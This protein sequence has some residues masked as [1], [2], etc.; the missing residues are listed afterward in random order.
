MVEIIEGHTTGPEYVKR[1]AKQMLKN[2]I[3]IGTFHEKRFVASLNTYQ[4]VVSIC[5][6]ETEFI[7]NLVAVKK[8]IEREFVNFPWIGITGPDG[9]GTPAGY[10]LWVKLPIEVFGKYWF[11]VKSVDFLHEQIC[12]KLEVIRPV[13][14]S[15]SRN[16]S[17]FTNSSNDVLNIS[18]PNIKVWAKEKISVFYNNVLTIDNIKSTII[19]TSILLSTVVLSFLDII[20][21]LLEYL[22]KLINELSKLIN[23]LT[24]ITVHLINACG[25]IIF[26]L[27]HLIITLFKRNPPP[28]P[29]YNAYISYDPANGMPNFPFNKNFPKALP[30]IPRSRAT[31]KNIY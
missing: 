6:N 19:F 14:D 26:G 20:K 3:F 17:S 12:L 29:V 11:K 10:N 5:E 2:S 28:Q 21:Y 4:D 15:S 13:N 18:I 27:F 23:T 24:P 7:E 30:N 9:V 16:L 31:I 25:R 1:F 8:R 22:L